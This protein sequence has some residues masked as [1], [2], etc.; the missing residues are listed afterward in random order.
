[1][2]QE[3]RPVIATRRPNPL[4]LNDMRPL[5]RSGF[6]NPQETLNNKSSIFEIK[7]PNKN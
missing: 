7:Q 3:T 4:V 5:E 6:F 2:I 1:M